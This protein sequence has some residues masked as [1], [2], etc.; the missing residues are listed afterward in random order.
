[1]ISPFAKRMGTLGPLNPEAAEMLAV[2]EAVD[3]ATL[4]NRTKGELVLVVSA[5]VESQTSTKS[6]APAFPEEKTTP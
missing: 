3:P 2:P 5:E 4:Y 1:M 6:Y